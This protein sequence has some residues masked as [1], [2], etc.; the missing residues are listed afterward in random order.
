MLSLSL[1]TRRGEAQV[2]AAGQ[3]SVWQICQ[4]WEIIR[5]TSKNTFR[6]TS[7]QH[8]QFKYRTTNGYSPCRSLWCCTGSFCG[9][10]SES[11]GCAVHGRVSSTQGCDPRLYP[12]SPSD[13]N[14]LRGLQRLRRLPGLHRGPCVW[15]LPAWA[16]LGVSPSG[17]RGSSQPETRA[18]WCFTPQPGGARR[19]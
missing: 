1:S 6:W 7:G 14:H 12:H 18:L 9:N 15:G 10:S 17:S 8:G 3:G 11:Q 16:V 5:S 19:L 2:R 13:K 4:Y